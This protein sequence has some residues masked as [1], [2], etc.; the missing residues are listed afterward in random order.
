MITM[1]KLVRWGSSALF[2]CQDENDWSS[3]KRSPYNTVHHGEDLRI[4]SSFITQIKRFT[5][6]IR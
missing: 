5:Q 6:C 4:Q 3:L 1:M 2:D